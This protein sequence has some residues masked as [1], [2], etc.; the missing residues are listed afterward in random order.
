MSKGSVAVSK[1]ERYELMYVKLFWAIIGIVFVYSLTG[2]L[3]NTVEIINKKTIISDIIIFLSVIVLNLLKLRQIKAKLIDTAQ[4]YL[5]MRLFELT[6]FIF[7]ISFFNIG[8]WGYGFVICPIAITSLCKGRSPA[9]KMAVYVFSLDLLLNAGKAYLYPG[10]NIN[11]SVSEYIF[12]IGFFYVFLIFVVIYCDGI[13]KDSI[14]VDRENK[15]LL[16]ELREKYVQIAAA[17]DEIQ[18]QYE[19]SKET[20]TKL[21][22]VNK[23]LTKKVGE[24]YTLQQISQAISSIFDINELLKFVSD[25]ILGVMGVSNSTIIMLDESKKRLKIHTTNIRDKTEISILNDNI[26]CEVLF[27][28]L[29][30]GKPILNNFVDSDEYVFAK[31]REVSSLICIPL[32]TK[33]RKYGLVLIEH[34]YYNAFDNENVRLLDIIGQQVGIAIENAELYQQMQEFARIDGLTGIY[35]RLYF[36]ERYEMEFSKAVDEK[37]EL[38]LAIFDV[39]YF[40][41]F[42]DTYGHLFGDKVIRTIAELVS[43]SLRSTDII[44]RYGGEEFIILFPHTSLSEAHEKV[45]SLRSIISQAI[46]KDELITASMTASFGISNYPECTVSPKEL[47]KSADTALY[48]AKASGRNCVKIADTELLNAGMQ[49][50]QLNNQ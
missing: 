13:Y 18:N 50:L 32:L 23:E 19:K 41:R 14:K 22:D 34:K 3:W 46:I 27:D 16:E 21:E 40:K 28:V 49:F 5:V 25:I 20:N 38:S 30:S 36:Q 15:G 8:Y 43:S 7:I 6:F 45:E 24:F 33:A 31:G 39:D 47:L 11:D 2:K 17:Q 26:N 48:E 44:A 12:Y 37:Y 4:I 9:L 29:S 35:N 1:S 42:N 10:F